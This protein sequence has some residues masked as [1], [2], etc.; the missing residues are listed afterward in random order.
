[1]QSVIGWTVI[2]ARFGR[3]RYS[4]RIR[5]DA[6]DA[7]PSQQGVDLRAEPGLVPRFEGYVAI[8]KTA[9]LPKE[10]FRHWRIKREA[11]RQL[12]QYRSEERRVGKEWRAR[13][14]AEQ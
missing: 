6:R 8:E 9:Q 3:G 11:R 10:P 7:M 13:W 4:R 14:G 5:G 2:A 12:R 1:M